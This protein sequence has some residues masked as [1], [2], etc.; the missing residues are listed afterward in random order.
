MA[1]RGDA[2]WLDVEGIVKSILNR[3]NSPS[4]SR[5]FWLNQITASEESWVHPDAVDAAIDPLATS[6]RINGNDVL[7]DGWLVMPD[8][9]IVVFF[10]GSKSDD[11]TALIGCR[12][13]DGY[14]FTLGVWQKPP[15]KRG[16]DWLAPR[17]QVD[18]R[19]TEMFERFNVVAFWGDPSH[20]LDDADSSRYWDGMMDDWHKR[21]RDR[22]AKDFWAMKS[23]DRVH[24]ILWDMTSPARIQQFV[25]AAEQFVEEIETK[26]DIEQFAPQFKIDGHP[27]LV[28]HLK[29]AIRA[30]GKW[31]VSL[32]KEGREST[33][34]IDLAV[35]AAGA[36]MLR[37]VVLN[38][39]PADTEDKP[40]ELWGAW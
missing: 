19:V 2:T 6:A 17:G 8:E 3:K 24:S 16:E 4:R 1:V 26:N 34:K 29:N 23:G 27:A 38:R 30:P 7:R 9:E 10:D 35:A 20:A 13:T 18:T 32:M 12:L 5:R 31:G 33:R 22:L 25:A 15:G 11:S 28:K 36:R 37:R 40:G 14:V 39:G 21:Y